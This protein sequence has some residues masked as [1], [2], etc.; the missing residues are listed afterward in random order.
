MFF[1]KKKGK[2]MENISSSSYCRHFKSIAKII[3]FSIFFFFVY[4]LLML[5]SFLCWFSLKTGR[6]N[7]RNVQEDNS[8]HTQQKRRRSANNIKFHYFNVE[9]FSTFPIQIHKIL[10]A[11]ATAF[12]SVYSFGDA[13]SQAK[14]THFLSRIGNLIGNK[15]MGKICVFIHMY[16]NER[17][18]THT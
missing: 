15:W 17:V 12:F 5:Y 4:C 1:Y 6:N 13:C 2:K 14:P 11:T 8:E 7:E 18:R 16:V 10:K 3:P 9:K